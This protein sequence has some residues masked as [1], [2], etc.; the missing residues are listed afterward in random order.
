[1]LNKFNGV[2]DFVSSGNLTLKKVNEILNGTAEFGDYKFI[3][4]E[5]KDGV[6]WKSS[7]QVLNEYKE[8]V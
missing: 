7:E 5:I 4:P 2:V 8:L 1:M 3:T 6:S